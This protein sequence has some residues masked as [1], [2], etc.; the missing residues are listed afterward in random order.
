MYFGICA[1]LYAP[2]LGVW[3]VLHAHTTLTVNF[4]VQIQIQKQYLKFMLS[5]V[6]A[7]ISLHFSLARRSSGLVCA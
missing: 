5:T 2:I 3:T 1:Y 7:Q 4:E 6:Y